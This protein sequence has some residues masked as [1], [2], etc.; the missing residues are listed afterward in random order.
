[1]RVREARVQ[2]RAARGRR[3]GIP[4]SIDDIVITPEIAQALTDLGFEP[5]KEGYLQA[6]KDR[7]LDIVAAKVLR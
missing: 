2:Q 1:M 7:N 4:S 5:T 3:Q 6:A